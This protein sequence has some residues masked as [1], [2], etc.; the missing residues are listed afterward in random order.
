MDFRMWCGEMDGTIQSVC[1]K[2][3]TVNILCLQKFDIC[4]TLLQSQFR[5]ITAK[6]P[7]CQTKV[8]LFINFVSECIEHWNVHVKDF[9]ITIKLI[10]SPNRFLNLSILPSAE[11]TI[12]NTEYYTT[13]QWF[14]L[15]VL[16]I[17][18]EIEELIEIEELT[19]KLKN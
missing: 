11:N 10:I 18:C 17:N 8:W 19:V 7:A 5:N 2:N 1:V 9:I 13:I 6:S 16:R 12:T 3:P 15:K 4:Y 14:Y